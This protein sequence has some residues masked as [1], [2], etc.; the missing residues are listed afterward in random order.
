MRIDKGIS[1][2]LAFIAGLTLLPAC[3]WASL[4]VTA[5]EARGWEKGTLTARGAVFTGDASKTCEFKISVPQPGKYQ[6]FVYVH[7]NWRNRKAFPE[8]FVEALDA[9]NK[10]HKGSHLIE[11]IWYLNKG[12]PGR[13]FM[14]SVSE[15]PYWVL[16]EGML[17]LKFWIGARDTP[18]EESR[19]PPEGEVAIS[20]VFLMPVLDSGEEA[21]SSLFIE[22]QNGEG[23]WQEVSYHPAYATGLIRARAK[24]AVHIVRT[25]IPVSGYYRSLLSAFSPAGNRIEMGI[26]NNHKKQ[27]LPLELKATKE[28]AL[29]ES[30]SFYLEKGPC[31]LTFATGKKS[32][33]M[34]DYCLLLRQPDRGAGK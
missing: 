17:A 7:H 18:W 30:P 34:L 4:A 19:I 5:K 2:S 29:V 15:N 16:P 27:K 12:Y 25:E 3:A 28:W 23:D 26:E 33:V 21:F 9:K 32:E 22:P 10:A 31:V 24:G 14:V 11:N 1:R 8:I 20:E 6:L 13:W